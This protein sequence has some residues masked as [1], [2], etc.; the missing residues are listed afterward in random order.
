MFRYVLSPIRSCNVFWS[1]GKAGSK[2]T[3]SAAKMMSGCCGMVTGT[4][5]PQSYIDA[6]TFESSPLRVMFCFIS[7]N[8][9]S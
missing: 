1:N 2:Y 6:D 4:D 8:M 7:S 3:Q 9:G 5:S